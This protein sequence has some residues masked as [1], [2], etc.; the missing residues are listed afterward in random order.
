MSDSVLQEPQPRLV[1]SLAS[2]FRNDPLLI[3]LPAVFI[4]IGIAVSL[5]LPFGY[6]P[7][8]RRWIRVSPEDTWIFLAANAFFPCLGIAAA[9]Y[10]RS[11]IKAIFRRG[12]AGSGKIIE[13]SDHTEIF[14]L[15]CRLVTVEYEFRGRR[16][17]TRE[18]IRKSAVADSMA[19][20]QTIE[21][22]IDPF[23]RPYIALISTHYAKEPP[24]A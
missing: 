1:P 12:I 13:I 19:A 4:L 21:I 6:V 10:V 3:L 18:L 20:G 14:C 16:H 24:P 7:G 15:K 2:S 8:K 17:T 22:M 9:L 23:S 11:R 5:F